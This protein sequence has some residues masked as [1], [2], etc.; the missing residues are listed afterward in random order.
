M[1][2]DLE[3]DEVYSHYLQR[4]AAH[5][6]LVQYLESKNI[7]GYVDL[8]LGISEPEGNYSASE[9]N[10]GPQVLKNNPKE[11]V[12]NLAQKIVNLHDAHHIP[13]AIYKANLGYLRISLGSEMAMMLEPDKFWVGNVRTIYS[14]LLIKH[15]G[16]WAKADEELYLYR[17]PDG[18]RPSVMEYKIWRDLYL[19]LENSLQQIAEQG[20]EEAR[21]QGTSNGEHVYMW[22]DAISSYL[23]SNHA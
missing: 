17:E 8:A 22:A 2:S 4:L 16:D 18:R 11:S 10:L 13:D 1:L 12:Y 14:H 19:S 15:S 21:K 7:D 20:A 5:Q 3:M 9:H 6:S 23:Y